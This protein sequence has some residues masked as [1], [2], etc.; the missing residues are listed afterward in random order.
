MGGPKLVFDHQMAMDIEKQTLY[1]FGGR[2]LSKTPSE[3][4]RSNE[5]VFS[6]LYAYH[7]PTNMWRKLKDDC[8]EMRS[9]IGHSMLLHPKSRLLYVFAG[10]RAKEYLT[11]F[12]TYNLDTGEIILISDGTRKDGAQVPAAGFT[13]RA[14]L[15][16]ELNEIHVLSGLSKDKDKR[17]NVRNSFWVY[18]ISKGKWSCIYK[19]ETLDQ[20]YWSRMQHVEPVPR[21]A[22]Q[23]VYDHI[24][25]VHYLFGGNP[26]KEGLPKMRLDDFWALQL[27][28]PSKEHLLRRCKYLIRKHRF[29]EIASSDP[30]SALNFLQTK[31]AE[32]VDHSDAE[33]T[34]D[35]QLL[36][37]TL[38]KDPTEDPD[39]LG[40]QD[41]GVHEHFTSRSKLF[42][43]LVSFF[44]EEMTQPKG[45]L[46]DVITMS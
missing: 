17:D 8:P 6:G 2:V 20:K 1:V 36:A 44:P 19:N 7:V 12:F 42:D 45:N 5:Q 15:D 11:D 18:D 13:Q 25:K 21:F 38:F 23:L 39:S 46:V 35:F 22:H 14:T 43:T 16:P 37:S 41:Q 33:E 9:R 10:Q 26:G 32:T 24:R 3:V 30:I 34:R 31:L 29:Q 28:R 40:I 27:C 4:E